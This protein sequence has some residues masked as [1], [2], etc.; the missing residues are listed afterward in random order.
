MLSLFVGITAC[1]CAELTG[2]L[3]RGN[4]IELIEN[5]STKSPLSIN[6]KTCQP[7]ENGDPSPILP[8]LGPQREMGPQSSLGMTGFVVPSRERAITACLHSGF[9]GFVLIKV[10]LARVVSTPLEYQMIVM[11]RERLIVPNPTD[12]KRPHGD[13]L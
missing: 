8:S 2:V 3:M 12:L 10:G 5:F 1:S 13:V 4:D 7:H 11:F 9:V 6:H